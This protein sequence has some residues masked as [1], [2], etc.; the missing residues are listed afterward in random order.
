MDTARP[1]NVPGQLNTYT[2][3]IDSVVTG[4]GKH[5]RVVDFLPDSDGL[6]CRVDLRDGLREPTEREILKVA[7]LKSG[8]KGRWKLRSR[9]EWT[10][11]PRIDFHFEQV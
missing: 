11:E 4:F 1:H 3:D 2:L 6:Y 9:E 10:Y 5:A 7:R 8:T